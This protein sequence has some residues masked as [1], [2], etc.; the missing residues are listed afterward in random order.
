MIIQGERVDLRHVIKA[1][2]LDWLKEHVFGTLMESTTDVSAVVR[3][4]DFSLL[5]LSEA[6]NTADFPIITG[7]LI[8]KKVKEAY[9]TVAKLGDTLTS[10]MPSNKMIDRIPGIRRTSSTKTVKEGMPYEHTAQLG[11]E[12]VDIAGSKKGQILDITEEMVRFD[13]TNMVLRKASGIGEDTAMERERDI[14]YTIQDVAGYKAWHPNGTQVDLYQTAAAAPHEY[15]TLITNVLADH[16]DLDTAYQAFAAL[17]NEN[18]M[19]ILVQPKVLL[20]PS[21]LK[22]T[23]KTL[24][25]SAV[26]LGTYNNTPNPVKGDLV[27]ESTPFLDMQSSLCWYVGDFKKQFVWKEIIPFQVQTRNKDTEAG[28]NQDIYAQFKVRYMGQC[29][30]LDYVY[31]IKSNGT[32]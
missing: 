30:A 28:W 10:N 27:V 22:M 32:T 18:G 8:S 29:A 20:V 4:E 26:Q 7:L 17:R 31:V 15:A 25:A 3:C 2:G 16:T 9:N 19:P 13:Q 1:K 5:E 24:M 21:A 12:Y 11:E 14:L 6:V 23:A